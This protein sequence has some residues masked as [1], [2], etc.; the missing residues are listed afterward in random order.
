MK[1]IILTVAAMLGMMTMSANEVK[2]YTFAIENTKNIT[3]LTDS[4]AFDM[5]LNQNMRNMRRSFLLDDEQQDMLFDIQKNV[6]DGF[7]SLNNIADANHRQQ[8]FD[9]LVAYWNR[10]AKL[11]FYLTERSD[12]PQ[13]YRKYWNCVNVTLHNKGYVTEDGKFN[14]NLNNK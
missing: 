10:G 9:S 2:N 7:R 6:E 5:H 12:A 8:M 4:T 11:S 14:K 3:A 13:C 1:K